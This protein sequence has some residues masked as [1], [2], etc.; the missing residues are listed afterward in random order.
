MTEKR[1]KSIYVRVTEKE[2]NKL[3][4]TAKKCGLTLSAYLRQVGLGYEPKE[5]FRRCQ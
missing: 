4:T 3:V 5:I 1:N 2:K